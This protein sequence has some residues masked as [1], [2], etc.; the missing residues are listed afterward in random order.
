L[1]LHGGTVAEEGTHVELLAKQGLYEK[2]Y[3]L[4]FVNGF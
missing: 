4:Q 3:R 1:V 2:L